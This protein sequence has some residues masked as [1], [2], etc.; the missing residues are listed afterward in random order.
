[1]NEPIHD[2]RELNEGEE[3]DGKF[4][5]SRAEAPVAFETAEDTL[6]FQAVRIRG[7][8]LIPI[9]SR[10]ALVRKWA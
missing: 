1:M 6:S 5:V 7:G 9:P 8:T 2:C 10:R 4:L 3:R